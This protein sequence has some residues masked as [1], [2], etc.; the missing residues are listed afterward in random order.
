MM[1]SS[2]GLEKAENHSCRPGGATGRLRWG[3]A[4]CDTGASDEAVGLRMAKRTLTRAKRVTSAEE[5]G[6]RGPKEAGTS[7][8]QRHRRHRR[9]R[10]LS[11]RA[12]G[13]LRSR[14]AVGRG[15]GGHAIHLRDLHGALGH[16]VSCF[17]EP[18]AAARGLEECPPVRPHSGRGIRARRTGLL[19][20]AVAT[21]PSTPSCWTRSSGLHCSKADTPG[22]PE[23]RPARRL[24][25]GVTAGVGG[26]GGCQV[27]CAWQCGQKYVLR[28]ISP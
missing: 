14:R 24:R 13:R 1:P 9:H 26:D 17:L 5:A 23:S 16:R 4:R 12:G 20:S 10:E 22:L 6:A 2:T 15:P 8:H 19:W 28:A 7:P 21:S 18:P 25:D 27:F 3:C 11:V